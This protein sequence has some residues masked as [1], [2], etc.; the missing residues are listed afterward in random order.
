VRGAV[1]DKIRSSAK[2]RHH[3]QRDVAI[4]RGGFVEFSTVSRC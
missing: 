4:L 2:P 3:R 1:G